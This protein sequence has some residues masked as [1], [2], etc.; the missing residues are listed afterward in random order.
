MSG[1]WGY[2]SKNYQW[3]F[4]GTGVALPMGLMSVLAWWLTST[5]NSR[6]NHAH[7]SIST[8][9]L[10]L[11][12]RDY[13]ENYD[14]ALGIFIANTGNSPVHI[15]RALFKNEVVVLGMFKIERRTSNLPESL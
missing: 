11:R 8:Q 12:A 4:S 6:E 13:H 9:N 3:I 5:H 2:I 14:H 10:D 1:M 7:L 15:W